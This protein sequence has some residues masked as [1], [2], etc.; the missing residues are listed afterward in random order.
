M[1]WS[2]KN[3]DNKWEIW[4][5]ITDSVIASFNEEKECVRFIAFE[6]IY[7]GK[8]KAIEELLCFPSGWHINNERQ[9][10]NKEQDEYFEWIKSI[11]ENCDTYK[12]YYKRIDQKLDELLNE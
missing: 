2:I 1:G 7:K 10:R 8:K 6:E 3:K 12:E 9:W 11:N 5:S 4:S